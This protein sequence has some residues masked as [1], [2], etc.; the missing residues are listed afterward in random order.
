MASEAAP[1]PRLESQAASVERGG[2]EL[3]A[4]LVE[5]PGDVVVEDVLDDSHLGVVVKRQVDVLMGDEVDRRAL[6]GRATNG[7]P[8]RA[9]PGSEQEERRRKDW[10]RPVLGVTEEAP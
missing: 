8:E 7:E 1:S 4:E 5:R 10:A 9:V 3:G 6:A 2:V